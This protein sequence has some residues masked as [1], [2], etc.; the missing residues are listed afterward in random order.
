MPSPQDN[1][2]KLRVQETR[3]IGVFSFF[4]GSLV[5]GSSSMFEESLDGLSLISP[6]PPAI[7]GIPIVFGLTLITF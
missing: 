4:S 7:V 5:N 1:K 6:T 3:A 2:M